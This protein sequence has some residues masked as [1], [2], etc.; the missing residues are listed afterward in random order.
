MSAHAAIAPAT[1][2]SVRRLPVGRMVVVTVAF[3][4]IIIGAAGYPFMSP[5]RDS[6]YP[7]VSPLE[8]FGDALLGLV[9]LVVL[10]VSLAR[11][12]HGRLWKL[13]FVAFAAQRIG[14]LMFVPNSLVWSLAR[15]AEQVGVGV[16]VHLLL[17][18][19]SGYLRD[20]LD[21]V[22]VGLAYALGVA[23]ALNELL[24]VGDRVRMGCDPDCVQ[25]VFVV[26]PNEELYNWL[27]NGI[28]VAFSLIVLPLVLVALWRH[29]RAAAPAARRTLLP[30]VFG[31]PLGLPAGLV[32]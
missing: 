31:V 14:T 30:L 25:N 3:L 32:A 16:F 12:P 1:G 8:K 19:P 26:L 22:V 13:I 17:A 29:W 15:I 27:R 18:F 28:A 20:R 4:A 21:R 24:F 2:A 23:W 9:W 7:P 6:W 10:L 5:L 11:Q